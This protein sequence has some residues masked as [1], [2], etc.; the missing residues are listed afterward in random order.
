MLL[1]QGSQEAEGETGG[2]NV[3]FRGHTL[4]ASIFF[5]PTPP[6]SGVFHWYQGQDEA[7]ILWAFGDVTLTIAGSR[8]AL[9]QTWLIYRWVT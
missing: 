8:T 2:A 4:L 1:T 7:F 3:A 5:S 6:A 9:G